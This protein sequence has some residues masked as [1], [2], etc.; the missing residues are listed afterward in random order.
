MKTAVVIMSRVPE[1]GFTKTRLSD[2]ISEDECAE[3]HRA[4]LRDICRVVRQSEMS[5]FIYYVGP[6]DRPGG[7]EFTAWGLPA[8]DYG[9]FCFCPQKGAD[10]GE[11]MANAAAEVLSRY[12][13]VILLG[14]DMPCLTP[15]L[16]QETDERLH[17]HDLVI[18]PADDGGYYLL[19][20]K[21][22]NKDLF[23]DIPWGTSEVLHH[24]LQA[25]EKHRQSVYT[26]AEQR[27]IDT[28]T[29]L[30]AFYG[31]GMNESESNELD[32]YKYAAKLISKY[33]CRERD[34]L[35]GCKVEKNG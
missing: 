18:G 3:F 7:M 27:D 4:C 2:K 21:R 30:I 31:E 6:G 8:E 11:R 32:S 19:G 16:L 25:S 15:R 34:E 35:F 10:L 29:D 1:P 17:D 9:Y 23:Q 5:G 24:T 28:W 20:C 12:D 13:G 14:S 22:V 33:D 26:L